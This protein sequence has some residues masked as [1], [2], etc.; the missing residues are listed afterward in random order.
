[1]NTWVTVGFHVG[2]VEMTVLKDRFEDEGIPYFVKD[3]NN[4]YPLTTFGGAKV[5]V[6]EEDK[7][8]ALEILKETGYL[9]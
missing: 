7:E 5:Q 1:M 4:V 2:P 9:E 6:R 3:E 8:R